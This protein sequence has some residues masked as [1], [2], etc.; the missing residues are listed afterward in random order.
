MTLRSRGLRIAALLFLAASLLA[1]SGGTF[2]APAGAVAAPADATGG[3]SREKIVRKA[4]PPSGIWQFRNTGSTPQAMTH[5]GCPQSTGPYKDDVR[6][7]QDQSCMP[8]DETSIAVNPR[9]S[10]N[11][12]GGANDYRLGWGTSGFYT[13]KDG[14]TTWKDG[15]IPFPTLPD[16]DNLDGG[17]DPAIAFDRQGYV[18]YADLNF[19]RTD[20][21]NG[22]FVSRSLNG[23][24]TWSRPCVPIDATPTNPNDNAAKCGGIGDPRTPGDGVVTFLYDNNTSADG[25]ISFNDKEYIAVGPRPTGVAPKC[26]GAI[27]HAVVP[28]R[29]GTVGVDRIYVTWTFFEYTFT[30]VGAFY[31]SSLIYMSYSDDRAR[32]WSPPKPISGN[33]PFCMDYSAYGIR[34]GCSVNQ[35]SV[36]TVHPTTGFLYVAFYNGNTPDENQYLVVRSLNGGQ[37]FSQPA[38]VTPVYDRNYP[39]AGSDATYGENRPDCSQ[40][41]QSPGRQVLTNTC[42]RVTPA[43]NIVVDKRGGAYANDLYLVLSDNRS[44]TA[45]KSNT[46]I[47]LFKSTNGGRNWTRATRVNNDPSVLTGSREDP[48]STVRGNDQWFPW[49]DISPAGDLN[50]VFF[51]RRLDTTSTKIEWTRSRQY[52][53]NYLTW[54][55]GAQCRVGSPTSQQL[56]AAGPCVIDDTLQPQPTAPVNPGP[57]RVA[58]Q[59]QT[60]FPFRNFAISDAP[61]NMDYAFRAGLFIGDYNNVAVRGNTA[62]A[63]WTDARNGRSSRFQRGR[64]PACEQSDVYFD[65]YSAVSGVSDAVARSTDSRFL[66]WSC[67]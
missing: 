28:C 48:N 12:V 49:V 36:P 23:G 64:N 10:A 4:P 62:H 8:Q 32:S 35:F 11:L 47:Y 22:V 38:F 52:P 66:Y 33:A 57:G 56:P 29:T 60:R 27:N 9:N 15:I 53:G 45:R 63:L 44:G 3:L 54:L 59:G 34:P 5:I 41:G 67:P 51:D 25:S 18:Y 14:G 39:T 7:N 30:P 55:W 50:V 2:A 26:F 43:G 46:D 20:D 17:G 61:S 65:R 16:G 37:T 6:A 42:F 31:R 21:T 19:N 24:D 58:G 13:S 40:R 1:P